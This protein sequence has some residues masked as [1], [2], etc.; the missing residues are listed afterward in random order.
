[1]L[2]MLG[3]STK[4][5]RTQSTSVA[6]QEGRLSAQQNSRFALSLLDRELRVAGVGVAD[7]QPLVV[8]AGP[9]GM[10]FNADLV[11]LDTSDLG[12]VYINADADSAAVDV[13]KTNE[14]ITLPGTAKLYPDTNYQQN[15]GVPSNAETIS[16]WLSQDSTSTHANEYILF[17]RANARPPRVVARGIIYNGVADT[18]FQ[19]FK[20]D[21][22][23]VLTPI[24]PAALPL[25]HTAAIHGSPA[26]T[27]ASAVT[28]SIKQVK[29]Q[30]TSVYHDPRTRADVLR[31][32]QLTIHLMNAGLIRHTTCGNPPL[33]VTATAVVTPANG[34]T[35]FQPYVTISWTASVDDGAGEKDV[36]RYAI[37]R[38]LS[39]VATFDEPFASAPG[40][41]PPYSVQDADVQSGQ[42]WVYGVTA[43]DCTPA[44]SPMAS[45]ATVVIP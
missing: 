14:K 38:R 8:M 5:F 9:L 10:T 35:V 3:L 23:G 19:Y 33:G 7:A 41:S 24:L 4:L 44:S 11:S 34:I 18:I 16:Y 37:Y 28:D 43:L 2:L 21:T 17:R 32:M 42:S 45:T 29:V 39:A 31:R 20:T 27:G 30:F 15:V 13:L 26:D 22:L 12:S 25:I 36:E 6:M 1:M 40:G